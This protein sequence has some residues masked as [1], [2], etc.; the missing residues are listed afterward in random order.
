M[1]QCADLISMQTLL[2]LITFLVSTSCL[3]SAHTYV[4]VACSSALRLGLHKDVHEE[5]SLSKAQQAARARVFVAVLQF[6]TFLSLV[7]DLPTFIKPDSVEAG[8]LE[9]LRQ[10]PSSKSSQPPD[11]KSDIPANFSASAKQLELLTMTAAGLRTVFIH[12]NS[13][14]AGPMERA[15]SIVNMKEMGDVEEQFREWAKALSC[16]PVIP[17]SPETSAM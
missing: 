3:T 6:D 1:T 15:E 14:D 2:C 12:G 7:L 10:S 9:E 11:D 5:L 4:G 16:L 8:I 13:V 17:Q